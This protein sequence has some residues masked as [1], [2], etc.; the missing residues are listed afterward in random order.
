MT[1]NPHRLPR[2]VLPRHYQLVLEPDLEAATFAGRQAVVCFDPAFPGRP[3]LA[4]TLT[5]TLT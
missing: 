4:L 5:S 3:R 1:A 2:T